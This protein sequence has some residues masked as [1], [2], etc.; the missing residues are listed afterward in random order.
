MLEYAIAAGVAA[1]ISLV[2]GGLLGVWLAHR[3]FTRHY[4]E[5]RGEVAR[6][7]RI[8]EDKLSDDDPDL[9]ALL[10]KLN[11]AVS[12]TYKAAE[13]LENQGRIIRKKSEGAREVIASSRYIARMI[14]EFSGD[15]PEPLPPP[16]RKQVAAGNGADPSP[17]GVTSPAPETKPS[18]PLE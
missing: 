14:D 2:A 7:R 10:R 8:A 18:P 9:N 4:E 16:M 13:G 15:E 3:K 11:D 17:A 5:V 6:M 12:Q 1:I